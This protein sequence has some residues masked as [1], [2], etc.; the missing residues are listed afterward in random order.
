MY[1]SE[2]STIIGLSRL[3]PLRDV[4]G[5]QDIAGSPADAGGSCFMAML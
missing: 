2:N 3:L 4:D 1:E 5:G